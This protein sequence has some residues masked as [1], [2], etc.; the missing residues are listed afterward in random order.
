[1]QLLLKLSW[2]KTDNLLLLA[3]IIVCCFFFFIFM[4]FRVAL[5]DPML[6]LFVASSS[7]VAWFTGYGGAAVFGSV[8]A[9]QLQCCWTHFT[10]NSLRDWHVAINNYGL[11]H[12]SYVEKYIVL[13]MTI[14]VGLWISMPLWVCLGSLFMESFVLIHVLSCQQFLLFTSKA[15]QCGPAGTLMHWDMLLLLHASHQLKAYK[16]QDRY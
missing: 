9:D 12:D 14:T 4:V 1:M 5:G 3:D 15:L 10:F 13:W 16:L 7:K 8:C 2:P 6:V 11:C